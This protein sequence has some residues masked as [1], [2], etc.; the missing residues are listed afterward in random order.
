MDDLALQVRLVDLVELRDAER[1]HAGCGQVE[2]RRAAEATGADH[3]HLGVLQPL[4]TGHPDV[5][6]DQVA[7]VATYLVDGQLGG[8][9]DQRREGHGVLLELRGFVVQGAHANRRPHPPC[10]RPPVRTCASVI[11]RPVAR[12]VGCLRGDARSQK[13]RGVRLP[14]RERRAQLL[15]SAL[16]VFVAQG[17]HA[18]AMDDIAERAGVSKPVLYQHFPGKL[19]LY[20]ALLDAACDDDDRQLPR[21]RS[22]S[23]DDNKHAGRRG[24]DA[25]YDYVADAERRLPARLRVR[26]DQRAGRPRARRAGHHRVRR[27]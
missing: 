6:D 8:G 20:L 10:S 17:Y 4:L 5:G 24:D 22:P 15:S 27:R 12:P 25:F 16:E 7:A 13:P 21:A 3:Q 9:L 2:Q 18:A 1:P 14:R 19:D 26:P 11:R 23:T